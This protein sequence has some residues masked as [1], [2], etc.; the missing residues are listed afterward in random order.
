MDEKELKRLKELQ[1]KDEL[2]A[3]EQEELDVLLEKKEL[4]EAVSAGVK[5]IKE[6][7]AGLKTK[8][9]SLAVDSGGDIEKDP[10]LR[11]HALCVG[12]KNNDR[13]MVRQTQGEWKK[14]NAD[15]MLEVGSVLVP[16]ITEARILELLPTFG[17]ARQF[18]DVMPMNG[19]PI[20][21]PKEGTLPAWTWGIG[22]NTSIS[23][24]KPTV[25]SLSWT[26]KKGGTIV[27]LSSELFN[28]ANVQIG[29]YI[30]R[31]I[32]QAKGTG[33]DSQ[34]FCG[35]GSP[36]TGVFSTANTFGS[37][38]ATATVDPNS[39]AYLDL[40]NCTTGVDQNYLQ[41]A[42]WFMHR[43]ILPYI[44]GLKDQIGHPI[45]EPAMGDRPMTLLGFPVH[46]IE[47]APTYTFAK[48]NPGTPFI[49]HG[50]LIN[51]TI[52]DVM[53]MQV[54]LLTEATIDGTSLAQFDLV[55]IRAIARAAFNPGLTEK[56]SVIKTGDTH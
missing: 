41:G 50:N 25:G 3:G 11:F 39:I 4:H 30:I 19:N 33:E 29:N 56:Y 16:T 51:T 49:L 37:S 48:S 45:F 34:F 32:V 43:T 12:L 36:F 6:E 28:D 15:P 22:E 54:K 5:A 17:Q 1:K 55:G 31:K 40:L 13:E 44:W 35:G 27:V 20:T 7:I 24:T 26:P 53:G 38:L 23:S 8:V 47:N 2:S 14:K 9:N 52:G 18:M 21:I 46:L 10:A 42:G